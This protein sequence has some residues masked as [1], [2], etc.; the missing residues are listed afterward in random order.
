MSVLPRK[1]QI[2][3]KNRFS[4]LLTRADK[5]SDEASPY[6]VAEDTVRRAADL[7]SIKKLISFT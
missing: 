4:P 5:V 2:K 3:I 1:P 7:S 6:V